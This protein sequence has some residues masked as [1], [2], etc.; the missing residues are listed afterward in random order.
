MLGHVRDDVLLEEILIDTDKSGDT[1]LHYACFHGCNQFL[2]HIFR[3]V[4]KDDTLIKKILTVKNSHG[5]TLLHVA[6]KKDNLDITKLILGHV[7]DD[8]LLEE[9]LIDTDK[10]R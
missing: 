6:T 8:V 5:R 2:D 7:R 1:V 10:Q 9:M 4:K 3:H